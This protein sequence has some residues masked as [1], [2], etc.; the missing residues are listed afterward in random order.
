MLHIN[1]NVT[2]R[3]SSKGYLLKFEKLEFWHNFRSSSCIKEKADSC[4]KLKVVFPDTMTK[5]YSK[6]FARK[7]DLRKF[8]LSR[9]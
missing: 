6:I 9:L 5:N 2:C 4:W 3:S 1:L 8:C 7:Y